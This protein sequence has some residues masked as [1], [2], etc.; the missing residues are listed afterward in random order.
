MPRLHLASENP[1]VGE[2]LPVLACLML[3]VLLVASASINV[4]NVKHDFSYFTFLCSVQIC[5]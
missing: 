4:L 1:I 2:I 5:M 3:L